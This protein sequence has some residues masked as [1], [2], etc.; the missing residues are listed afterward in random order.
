MRVIADWI[1]ILA[2]LRH[3]FLG[4]W[5]ELSRDRIAGVTGFDQ[6]RNIRGHGHRITRSNLFQIGKIGCGRQTAGDQFGRPPQRG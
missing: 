5:N 3:Q 2:G 6:R 1:G 4:T